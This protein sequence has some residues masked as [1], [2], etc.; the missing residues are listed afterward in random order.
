MTEGRLAFI[1]RTLIIMC[2]D[3]RPGRVKTRL[4]ADIGP[5]PAA[6]WV[7]R[8]IADMVRSLDHP[9]WDMVLA[10]A[11]D[12][13]VGSGLL[14]DLPRLPQGGGDLGDRMARAFRAV[15]P[16]PVLIVGT[17]IPGMTRDHVRQ[18]FDLIA[19]HKA[20][21]G[22]ATDGGFWA[23]G[24]DTRRPIPADLFAGVRWSTEH[25]LADTLATCPT[26]AYLPTL[27]DVDSAADLAR[28]SD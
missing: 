24:L 27:D 13:A 4:A 28:L 25:A 18:G 2:K 17:D 22:P 10:V 9:S 26:P 7:R 23:I 20:V 14:P 8:R 15:T 6:L 12:T 21:L 19:R 5:L 16:G 1:A 11:P 3:P